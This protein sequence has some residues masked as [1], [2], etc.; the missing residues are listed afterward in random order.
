MHSNGETWSTFENMIATDSVIMQKSKVWFVFTTRL[1]FNWVNWDGPDTVERSNTVQWHLF[2][3]ALKVKSLKYKTWKLCGCYDEGKSE[4]Y[5][6]LILHGYQNVCNN[7]LEEVVNSSMFLLRENPWQIYDI[8]LLLLT[9][10]YSRTSRH[11][12]QHYNFCNYSIYFI[13]LNC[14]P[15]VVLLNSEI[16]RIN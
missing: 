9:K 7:D 4:L 3:P 5:L 6:V 15:I 13:G 11:L 10:W 16:Q 2:G 8:N 12:K 14:F 1:I